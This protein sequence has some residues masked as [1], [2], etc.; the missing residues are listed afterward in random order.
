MNGLVKKIVFAI[1]LLSGFCGFVYQVVWLRLAFAAFGINTQVI[2]VV[3]SMFML[4]LALGSWAAGALIARS[5]SRHWPRNGIFVYALAELGIGLGAF[6][7]PRLFA[8]GRQWLLAF[9]STDSFYYLLLSALVVAVSIV[10]WCFLMGTTIP[11]MIAYVNSRLTKDVKIFSYLYFA[12]TAGAVLGAAVSAAVLIEIFGFRGTLAVAAA[13]NTAIA[14][15]SLVIGLKMRRSTAVAT[16]SEAVAEAVHVEIEVENSEKRLILPIL[17]MTG[18]SSMG[19]EVAWT[20]IFTPLVGTTVYSFAFIVIIYLIGTCVGLWAYRRDVRRRKTLTSLALL[21]WLVLI[22]VGQIVLNDPWLGSGLFRMVVTIFGFAY[23]LGY[24]TPKQ[25]DGLSGGDSAVVGRSYAVNILGCI[26]GPL[27]TSYL[28]IPLVGT[29]ITV[30]ALSLPYIYFIWQM[31]KK[32]VEISSKEFVFCSALTVLLIFGFFGATYEEGLTGA[33]GIRLLKR[34]YNAT[35]VAISRSPRDKSLLVNGFG[36]TSLT[37]ITK[38]MAHLPYALLQ[39]RPEKAL[40]ICF[41]MGTTFRSSLSW[42][43]DTTAVELTPSVKDVFPMFFSD[44]DAVMRNPRGR[45]VID[46]GRRYLQH[47]SEKYDLIT[48]D[49]PPPIAAAG[50]SLLYSKEFYEIAKDHLKEGGILE[51]W[52]PD[53][54]NPALRV[55]SPTLGATAR[56]LREVFPYVDVYLS[57]EGWGYHFIA[58]KTPINAITPEQFVAVMPEAAKA[59]LMEWGAPGN[60]DISQY[61]A[62]ILSRKM[63]FDQ[64]LMG[65]PDIVITDD[66]PFNEYYLLRNLTDKSGP[67]R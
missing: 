52:F 20:R 21:V 44:A 39:R 64:F 25:I 42:D 6:V 34:D 57:V 5:G 47:T 15:T 29:K 11:L 50:S 37:P 56:S 22:S 43:V 13:I 51:Q 1:F 62:N 49:P 53:N 32:S 4:G 33:R 38:N 41:G 35:V 8:V 3:V 23:I 66:R 26:V 63:P 14:L 46:D 24:L 12:N 45:V 16:S 61:A 60:Q 36:M 27:L 55:W 65:S 54:E 40:V 58:S 19:L 48:I 7:V 59:D 18:L 67:T 9:G 30:L 2:S 31:R 28:L 10:P 17:F